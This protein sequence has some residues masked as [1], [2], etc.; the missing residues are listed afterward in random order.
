MVWR[1]P[2]SGSCCCFLSFFTRAWVCALSRTSPSTATSS[3]TWRQRTCG[4]RPGC[5]TTWLRFSSTRS[6][7]Q[8]MASTGSPT[9]GGGR[10]SKSRID[11]SCPSCS[12]AA[13]AMRACSP[14]SAAARRFS[15]PLG[16]LRSPPSSPTGG[17]VR[18]AARAAAA[19]RFSAPLLYLRGA[20]VDLGP[21]SDTATSVCTGG[22]GGAPGALLGP[23][24]FRGWG[25]VQDRAALAVG[26]RR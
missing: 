10:Q 8:A 12:A 21:S 7:A 17:G 11:G 4:S 20:V 24:P 5:R 13:L 15:A 23:G 6:L 22:P 18:S 2:F 14:R 16:Y 19:L 1:S 3:L 9:G 25:P 26:D